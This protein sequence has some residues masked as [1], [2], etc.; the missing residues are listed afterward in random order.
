MYQR[1]ENSAGDVFVRKGY[2][3][4]TNAVVFICMCTSDMTRWHIMVQRQ[5]GVE[6]DNS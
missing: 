2:C 3:L 5:L 6:G 1:R 4:K